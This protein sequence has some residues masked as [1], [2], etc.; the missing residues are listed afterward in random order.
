MKINRALGFIILVITLKIF[1][2]T[3]FFAFND[4]VVATF[5]A[6]KTTAHVAEHHLN[7]LMGK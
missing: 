1:F 2:T 3:S 4:T 5:H 7:A 6:M